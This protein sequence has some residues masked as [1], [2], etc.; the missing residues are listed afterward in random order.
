[1]SCQLSLKLSK[2]ITKTI[3]HIF[4]TAKCRMIKKSDLFHL[5]YNSAAVSNIS[6]NE[7][8]LNRYQE[9]SFR[10]NFP[11]KTVYAVFLKLK[12]SA[13]ERLKQKKNQWHDNP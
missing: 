12:T 2:K 3:S 11:V 7:K 5:A 8:R 1:M 9:N 4:A 6:V 13:C 10:F